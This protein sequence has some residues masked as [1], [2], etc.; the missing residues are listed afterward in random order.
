MTTQIDLE[1]KPTIFGKVKKISNLEDDVSVLK[2]DGNKVT[3]L[4]AASEVE[5]SRRTVGVESDRNDRLRS[6]WDRHFELSKS[7]SER[8][9]IF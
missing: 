6:L 9:S 7:I 1:E 5:H 8:K 3:R 2:H 4:F